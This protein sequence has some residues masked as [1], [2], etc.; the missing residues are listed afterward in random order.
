MRSVTGNLVIVVTML[1]SVSCSL[2]HRKQEE[3]WGD[4]SNL[5]RHKQLPAQ[6]GNQQAG[7]KPIRAE[8][9]F[10]HVTST[11]LWWAD[12]ELCSGWVM[13]RLSI[14]RK[15]HMIYNHWSENLA[16]PTSKRR[17]YD[18]RWA[19]GGA[20]DQLSEWS[21]STGFLLIW[22]ILVVLLTSH[23]NQ[24]QVD[25]APHTLQAGFDPH[26]LSPTADQYW[27]G[28]GQDK[29]HSAETY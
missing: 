27:S 13:L 2:T 26:A 29:G 19:V 10:S 17:S 20:A 16:P 4:R 24:S 23:R 18:G 3:R 15:M 9:S 7:N 8:E 22:I 25:H 5:W 28:A 21:R 14:C 11:L 12:P 1:H 6:G